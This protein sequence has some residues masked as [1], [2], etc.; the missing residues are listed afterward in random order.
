[1]V[2]AALRGRTCAEEEMM[3]IQR[4]PMTEPRTLQTPW[5]ESR[6]PLTCTDERS[7]LNIEHMVSR[8]PNGKK[9]TSQH[10]VCP[11]FL[12]SS[13]FPC[14]PVSLFPCLPVD[15]CPWLPGSLFTVSR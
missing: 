10:A 8:H 15:L 2:S 11:L 7:R 5:R 9:G 12:S 14:L 3:R 6:K 4:G 13:L 1:M